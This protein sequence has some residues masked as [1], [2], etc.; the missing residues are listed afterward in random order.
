VAKIGSM[1][2]KTKIR[3]VFF[4][5]GGYAVEATDGQAIKFAI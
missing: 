1:A 4:V 2:V 5:G 3:G